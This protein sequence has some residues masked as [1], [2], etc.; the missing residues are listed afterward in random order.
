[1]TSDDDLWRLVAAR[2]VRAAAVP[3]TLIWSRGRRFSRELPG[4][5]P[6]DLNGDVRSKF[7]A[8]GFSELAYET[9]EPTGYRGV[10]V[11]PRGEGLAR[12]RSVG[13]FSDQRVS[14]RV[15]AAPCLAP[16]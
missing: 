10:P 4:V 2:G 6:G 7:E 9:R 15:G 1:M 3:A 11:V 12:Q 14:G 16:R 13:S 5:T 8:A